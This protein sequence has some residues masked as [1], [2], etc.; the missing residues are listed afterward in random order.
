M[1]IHIHLEL[2]DEET[3]YF[4][5]I[6]EDLAAALERVRDK[7]YR[8]TNVDLEISVSPSKSQSELILNS[9]SRS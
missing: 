1:D 7:I 2:N 6:T 3:E 4:E 9:S 5:S 8:M